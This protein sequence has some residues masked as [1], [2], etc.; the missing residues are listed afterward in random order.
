MKSIQISSHI[1]IPYIPAVIIAAQT[2]KKANALE[3]QLLT[4]DQ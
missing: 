3:K 1:F 2:N 4:S